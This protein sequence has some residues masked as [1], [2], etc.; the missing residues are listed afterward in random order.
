MANIGAFSDVVFSVSNYRVFTF[1]KYHRKSAHR[2]EEHKMLAREPVL[3]SV[4]NDVEEITLEIMMLKAAGIDPAAQVLKLRQ[5]MQNA[6]PDYLILGANV[7]NASKFVITDIDE[8]VLHWDG[9]GQAVNSKVKVTFKAYGER[10]D[11]IVSRIK[12]G[13]NSKNRFWSNVLSIAKSILKF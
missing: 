12:G 6:E 1:D 2:Y 9:Y 4:G 8:Q 3:E 7:I 10:G 5:L 11:E 13:D